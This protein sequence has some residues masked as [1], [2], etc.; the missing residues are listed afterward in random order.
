LSKLFGQEI[1]TFAQAFFETTYFVILSTHFFAML[2]FSQFHSFPQAKAYK[3]HQKE[4]RYRYVEASNAMFMIETN[5]KSSGKS[6]GKI[7]ESVM[8][9]Q[10]FLSVINAKANI[11]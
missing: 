10:Y 11:Q 6:N 7:L 9:V 2:Q 5:Q 1:G 4:D 3:M 8:H